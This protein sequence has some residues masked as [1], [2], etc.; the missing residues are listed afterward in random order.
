MTSENENTDV[1][2]VFFNYFI[3]FLWELTV[4]ASFV[5]LNWDFD[6]IDVCND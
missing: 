1:T 6:W 2:K 4:K 3:L 5:F